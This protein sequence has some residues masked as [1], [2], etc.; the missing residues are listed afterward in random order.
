MTGKNPAGRRVRSTAKLWRLRR[1]LVGGTVFWIAIVLAA[2]CQPGA[3]DYANST[4][5]ARSSPSWRSPTASLEVT[6]TTFDS[7]PNDDAELTTSAPTSWG[8]GV[9]YAWSR[10]ARFRDAAVPSPTT[11]DNAD[12]QAD[13]PLCSEVGFPADTGEELVWGPFDIYVNDSRPWVSDPAPAS[14]GQHKIVALH[15]PRHPDGAQRL[16]VVHTDDEGTA[17]SHTVL[18]DT[19]DSSHPLLRTS[20][21]VGEIVVAPDRWLIP[22]TLTTFLDPNQLVPGD[23]DHHA[24]DVTNI[25]DYG[26]NDWHDTRELP[27][28]KLGGYYYELGGEHLPFEC[29]AS[30]E[31]MGVTAEKFSELYME[32]GYGIWGA[33][34]YPRIRQMAGY[35]LTARWGEEPVRAQLPVNHG[36]CCKINILDTGFVAV[37]DIIP[38]GEGFRADYAPP[39]HFSLDGLTWEAVDVPTRYFS[40]D[41]E[42]RF[43]LPIWVCSAESSETGGV[44]IRQALIRQSWDSACS[45]VTY[46]ATDGGL[47]NWRKLLAPPSGHGEGADSHS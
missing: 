18:L 6:T 23:V 34:P 39:V 32:Y 24:I 31:Q 16:L 13:V 21:D 33:G 28:W 38:G 3:D 27:G 2:A 17:A 35:I 42:P 29:F 4:T 1:L 20:A 5:T 14:D 10:G 9:I 7:V 37:S 26:I 15:L 12:Q 46:W 30:W 25:N 45:E 19:T 41:G 40:Y 11:P 8:R 44:L 22:V 43:E 36:R 47:T